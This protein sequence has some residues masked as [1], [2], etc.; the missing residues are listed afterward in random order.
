MDRR[1]L[2]KAMLIGGGGLVVPAP[3]LWAAPP[4]AQV[5]DVRL[6]TAPDHTRVVFAMDRVVRHNLF[7]LKDPERLVL[8]IFD[9]KLATSDRLQLSDPVV[10]HVR[11]GAPEAGVIR[12]VFELR[13][14]VRPRTFVL[15]ATKDQK[16]RLVLDL[17]LKE[18]TTQ[19]APPSKRS[20]GREVVVVLDPGHGGEDPGA[21]GAGGTYEKNVVL[22][23][24]RKLERYINGVPGMRAH[25]TRTGDYYIPLGKRVAIAR[26]HEA[27]FFISIHADAFTVR[28][29]RGA[30]VYCLSEKGKPPPDRAVRQLV[31]RENSADL[32]GGVDL[33]AVSDREVAGI[34]MD[35]SQRDAI[36]RGLNLGKNLLTSLKGVTGLKFNAVQQAG[37]MV[38]KAPDIPSTL[39]E[40]AFLSNP[41]EEKLL[42]QESHQDVLAR[43][44]LRGAQQF[45]KQ[46]VKT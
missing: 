43:A 45:A 7:R 11:L 22:A 31:E 8:D 38:L 28:T 20:S 15:Q 12:T 32:I 2:L 13:G 26:N 41:D 35:L 17:Y 25:L 42:R 18:A 5:S 1:E 16:A 9:A 14:E 3:L 10:S 30:S 39:V 44:L 23:V 40:L 24:A 29:A 21:V 37:F 36:N 33:S 27:D 46:S 4:Y 6:W 19:E 34:L